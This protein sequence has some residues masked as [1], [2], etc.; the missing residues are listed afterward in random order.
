MNLGRC[1]AIHVCIVVPVHQ[2]DIMIPIVPKSLRVHVYSVACYLIPIIRCE[3]CMLH[4]LYLLVQYRYWYSTMEYTC[5]HIAIV[6][7]GSMLPGY[8][9]QYGVPS[10][11]PVASKLPVRGY[12]HVHTVY[13]IPVHAYTCTH[14]WYCNSMMLL[15]YCNRYCNPLRPHG[16]TVKWTRTW[17]S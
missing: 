13:A 4:F 3:C 8:V 15:Q 7:T 14:Q 2:K 1:M 10:Y 11:R 9:I 5:T 16:Y 17:R 6:G 12:V